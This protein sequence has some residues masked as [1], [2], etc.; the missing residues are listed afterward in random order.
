ML[1]LKIILEKKNNSSPSNIK[2][3]NKTLRWP[4][5]W[6][7]KNFQNSNF[8]L[9]MTIVTRL[10]DKQMKQHTATISCPITNSS[11]G[12]GSNECL[13]PFLLLKLHSLFLHASKPYQDNDINTFLRGAYLDAT[14][15]FK[16]L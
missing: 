15:L 1:P 2:Y 12:C 14:K 3:N 9:P 11:E 10:E 5:I 4:D 6:S 13:A 16:V 8:S 7:L